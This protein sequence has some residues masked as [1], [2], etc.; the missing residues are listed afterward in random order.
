[1]ESSEIDEVRE[2]FS[3]ASQLTWILEVFSVQAEKNEV[4][5]HGCFFSLPSEV[6]CPI[7]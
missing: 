6:T 7:A 3:L 5:E 1:M 4:G 2:T